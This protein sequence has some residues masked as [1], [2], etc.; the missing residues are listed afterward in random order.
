[1]KIS[2]S[3]TAPQRPFIPEDGVR[4]LTGPC[5]AHYNFVRFTAKARFPHSRIQKVVNEDGRQSLPDSTKVAIR[6]FSAGVSATSVAPSDRRF[7][8]QKMRPIAPKI[9]TA[10]G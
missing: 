4:R 6:A 10:G 3:K 2:V 5:R 8:T 1:M 7:R 9:S